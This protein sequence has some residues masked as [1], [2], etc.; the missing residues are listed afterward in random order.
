LEI[1]SEKLKDKNE[2]DWFNNF[3]K[4]YLKNAW[5]YLKHNCYMVININQKHRSEHYVQWMIDYMYD[6]FEDSS[7]YGVIS[8]RNK[9]YGSPQPMFVWKKV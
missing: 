9:S 4:K 3:F 6:E 8:Y 2:S 1:Y 5:K 7:Y